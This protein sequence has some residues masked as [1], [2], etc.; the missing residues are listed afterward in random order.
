MNEFIELHRNSQPIHVRA[1]HISAVEAETSERSIL[2]MIGGETIKVKEPADTVVKQLQTK[3]AAKPQPNR[4][5]AA[6][7]M[8]SAG[9]SRI[10]I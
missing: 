9:P 5:Q 6:N 1:D 8:M 2:H 10:R 3:T 7:S 4:Q